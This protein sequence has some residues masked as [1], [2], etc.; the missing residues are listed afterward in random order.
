MPTQRCAP[1]ASA[2]VAGCV[3]VS[4]CSCQGCESGIPVEYLASLHTQYHAFL[5][6]MSAL[7][8]TVLTFDW[9]SYGLT[10]TVADAVVKAET[11]VWTPEQ[12]QKFKDFIRNPSA[13]TEALTMPWTFADAIIDEEAGGDNSA[14]A[15]MLAREQTVKPLGQAPPVRG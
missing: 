7:G 6:E 10:Q 12:I 2:G 13:V 4:R 9:T 5:K 8:S 3:H 1:S 15:A 11:H 14:E